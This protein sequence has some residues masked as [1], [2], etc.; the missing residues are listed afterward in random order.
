VIGG[1]IGV[2]SLPSDHRNGRGICARA[3]VT[4]VGGVM[5]EVPLW[6]LGQ[7]REDVAEVYWESIRLSCT[8]GTISVE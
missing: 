5:V 8:E 1:S 3:T 4:A 7:R 2:S 6:I